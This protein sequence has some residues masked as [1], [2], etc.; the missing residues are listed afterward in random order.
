MQNEV[1]IVSGL[2]QEIYQSRWGYH[3]CDYE[4][5]RLIKRLMVWRL[6][7]LRASASLNRWS[8][9][10]PQNR[11]LYRW[12]RNEQGQKIYRE[13]VGP[14]PEPKLPAVWLGDE[15]DRCR[16]LCY[17][18]ATPEEVKPLPLTVSEL[19]KLLVGLEESS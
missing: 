2:T 19:K 4:T 6:R 14:W 13:K 7:C 11:T 12:V 17:P 18:V 9:K 15:I 16:W 8:A 5:F 1:Q 3:P 10:E